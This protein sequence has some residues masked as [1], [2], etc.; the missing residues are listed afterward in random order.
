MY[1]IDINALL[2]SKWKWPAAIIIVVMTLLACIYAFTFFQ[3]SA[4]Y[5]KQLTLRY[6]FE[7]R[8]STNEN[9]SSV[10]LSIFAPLKKT[11]YQRVDGITASHEFDV[12]SDNFGQQKL[13][14]NGVSLPPHGA[15]VI[16]ITLAVAIQK[17]G[18]PKIT[19]VAGDALFDAEHVDLDASSVALTSLALAKNDGINPLSIYR[20]LNTNI[21]SVDFL[22]ED[23]G[24]DYALTYLR[25]DCTE[26]MYAFLALS[27]F[28]GIPSWGYA[29]FVVDESETILRSAA[30][31]NWNEFYSEGGWHLADAQRQQFRTSEKIY[32]AFRVIGLTDG[33]TSSSSHRYISHDPR[34]AVR[35]L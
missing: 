30:Y 11:Q 1:Q 3:P 28:N 6:Q 18:N 35:M 20:W 7:V 25:G 29:G 10:A 2:A 26:F 19:F 8:N 31:H 23:R 16:T 17:E 22:P 32:L 5:S 27:R 4:I 9:L 21:T 15:D 24:A 33:L 12:S 14:F 34:I 13:I